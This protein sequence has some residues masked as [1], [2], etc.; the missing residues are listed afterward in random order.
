MEEL[1][2]WKL[3]NSCETFQELFDAVADIGPIEYSSNNRIMPIKS[4]EY[5]INAI[6]VA[7]SEE[8]YSYVTRNYGLRSK[9]IYLK[10]YKEE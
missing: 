3:V 5:V 8:N 7:C 9:V 4:A 2:K 10:Q 6:R 1:D